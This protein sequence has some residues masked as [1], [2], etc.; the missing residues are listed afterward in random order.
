M[1]NVQGT[2][3]ANNR[4]SCS[5]DRVSVVDRTATSSKSI[6][7]CLATPDRKR[8]RHRSIARRA[9]LIAKLGQKVCEDHGMERLLEFQPSADTRLNPS[10]HRV[11]RA[12]VRNTDGDP[13][14][15]IQRRGNTFDLAAMAS[16][17]DDGDLHSWLECMTERTG[18]LHRLARSRSFHL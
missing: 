1:Q 11:D 10:D 8:P 13:I 7:R 16:E 2:N 14:A 12:K 4:R 17:I 6:M 15:F 18:S 9:I 5:R 3:T